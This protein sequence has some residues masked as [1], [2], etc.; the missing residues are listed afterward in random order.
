LLYVYNADTD[1]ANWLTYDIN[2][3]P[4]T[5]EY[6]GDDPKNTALMKDTPLASKYNSGFTYAAQAPKKIIPTP[7]INFLQDSIADNQRYLKIRITQI[8]K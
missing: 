4:W 2:L 3:D 8:E 6:L 1:K 7:S 5:K